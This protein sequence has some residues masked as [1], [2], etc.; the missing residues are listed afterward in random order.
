MKRVEELN[1]FLPLGNVVM[2]K[3]MKARTEEVAAH[4]GLEEVLTLVA[5]EVID[6]VS[7]ADGQYL[8]ALANDEMARILAEHPAAFPAG[9]ATVCLRDMDSALRELRRA[10]E[11]LGLRGVQIATTCA[12]ENL[13]EEKYIPFFEAMAGYDLPVLIHPCNGPNS[14]PDFIFNWP[15]ETTWMMIRLAASGIFERLPGLKLVTHHLG[16]MV[17]TF[18]NRIYYTYLRE[19][20]YDGRSGCSDA[21]TA[22]ANLRR[23]YNDTALYGD[24]T[25][26]IEAGIAFFGVDHV[27]FGTD[28]P[29][30][31][32]RGADG[33]GQTGNTI[34]SIQRLNIPPEEKQKIFQDN[35]LQLLRLI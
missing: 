24:C 9:M 16:A 15:L 28:A 6:E 18:H 12:G 31:G 26:A 7:V 27:L 34:D 4:E 21:E 30:D 2:L 23:F 3:D 10:I 22:Y 33:R 20:F 1:V 29:L 14:K 25:A 13:D 17:P 32:D 8:A 19:G 11:E 35:A 5:P